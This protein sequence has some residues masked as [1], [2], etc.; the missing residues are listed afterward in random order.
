M[1]LKTTAFR[2][3]VNFINYGNYDKKTGLRE[4][5]CTEAKEKI[6]TSRSLEELLT[7][8]SKNRVC[9]IEF[10]EGTKSKITS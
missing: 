10:S 8:D 6:I 9:E 3:V 1:H 7:S 5:I 2:H 4:V